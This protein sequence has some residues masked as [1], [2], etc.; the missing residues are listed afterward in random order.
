MGAINGT[1]R[2]DIQGLRALAVLSVVI[3]HIS[4][5]HLSGGYLG[6]DIFFVISGYLIIGQLWR[7]I[8]LGT[9][10]FISFYSSRF[11]RLLP[12]LMA[13]LAVTSIFSYIFLLPAEYESY[14]DTV[15]SSLFYYSNFWF[16]SHSGY[17]SAELEFAPLLHTW[18]LSVEEQFYFIF[19]ILLILIF[20]YPI[21]YLRPIVFLISFGALSLILSELLL[22]IDAD[23][24]FYSSPTR[25]WQ[26]IFGGL[27]AVVAKPKLTSVWFQ[28]I[29]VSSLLLIVISLFLYNEMTPFPGVYAIPITLATTAILFVNVQNG[30]QYWLL[31]NKLSQFFGNISYS[32]YLWHWPV[33]VFYKLVFLEHYNTLDK[34]VIFLISILLATLSYYCIENPFRKIKFNIR[35]HS[36]ITTA[37]TLSCLFILASF[38]ST[39]FHKSTFS[40]EIKSYELVLRDDGKTFRKDQC[41]ITASTA[42]LSNFSENNCL[43][44]KEGM[45]NILLLGD[46]H[47][48]QWYV[49][50]KESLPSNYA[51]SQLT[52]GLCTATLVSNGESRCDKFYDWAINDVIP[53]GQ[54]D[55]IILGSRWKEKDITHISPMVSE[56]K[57]HSNQ[58]VII[59]PVIEYLYPLPWLLARR[60]PEEV[61]QFARYRNQKRINDDL[62]V[63]AEKAGASFYPA[64]TK[65]CP[66]PHLCKQVD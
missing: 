43:T 57:K 52:V 63:A 20:K 31:S 47:A 25:F 19:P 4:P 59:G 37:L 42:G 15:T 60:S 61:H 13:V 41:F 39:F 34:G 16:Y 62:K 50:L 38:S 66:T 2:L 65:L 32:F 51:L 24:S 35:Q 28:C 49:A 22:Y 27:A 23:F 14:V 36:F 45:N 10:S 1:Y 40:D 53:N 3:F 5:H 33:I 56:L 29:S 58:I 12:A 8:E 46:S 18:S 26:F 7:K 64:L 9:F 48:A 55:A 44:T 30:F 11:K 54:F 21:K 17:F 6:V